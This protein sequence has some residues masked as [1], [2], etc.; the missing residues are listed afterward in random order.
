MADGL[1]PLLTGATRD[2]DEYLWTL[3]GLRWAREATGATVDAE[4]F[5]KGFAPFERALKQYWYKFKRR[6]SGGINVVKEL[7]E[8]AKPNLDRLI[9]AD[10]RVTGLLG[11]YIVSLRGMGLVKNDSLSAIDDAADRLLLDISFAPTRSWA[12]SWTDLERSFDAIELKPARHRL[13]RQLFGGTS[14]EMA[15]AACAALARPMAT[16]WAHSARNKLD[17]E[18]RRLALATDPVLALQNA[19]LDAFGRLIRGEKALPKLVR[20]ELRALA[21]SASDAHP[22]PSS[23]PAGTP[24]RDAIHDAMSSLAHGRE[25]AATLLNL[26]VTVTREVRQAEPWLLHL[27]EIPAGFQDW[28]P[29]AS[30]ADFRFG[31][32]RRLL[33]Q[34]KWRP[35]AD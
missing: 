12:S 5:K 10:Q 1:V 22:F 14:I 25:A 32:L 11:N 4:L 21:T 15:N 8:E 16:S 29:G 34:T 3:I 28:Q 23:W 19:A 27:G 13:G 31:N 26:H 18:Q 2:A 24:L 35:H 30:G 20:S 6:K 9:L 17:S 7:C 33:R